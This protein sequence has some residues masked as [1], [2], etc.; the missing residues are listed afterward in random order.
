M[1][2]FIFAY[3]ALPFFYILHICAGMTANAYNYE[4]VSHGLKGFIPRIRNFLFINACFVGH[5]G[6]MMHHINPFDDSLSHL[7]SIVSSVGLNLVVGGGIYS[8]CCL[9]LPFYFSG[10]CKMSRGNEEKF[11]TVVAMQCVVESI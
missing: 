3:C 8:I 11:N 7:F 1:N 4:I 10:W 6:V 9:L 2:T 5:F